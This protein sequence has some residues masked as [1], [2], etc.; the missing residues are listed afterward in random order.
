[1]SIGVAYL[2]SNTAYI[3]VEV[4]QNVRQVLQFREIFHEIA[5]VRHTWHNFVRIVNENVRRVLQFREII[6]EIAA[7]MTSVTILFGVVNWS[8]QAYFYGNEFSVIQMIWW[9]D[10]LDRKG[11][12]WYITVYEVRSRALYAKKSKSWEEVND[13]VMKFKNEK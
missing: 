4:F 11:Y 10:G 6:H 9:K 3:F 12:Y 8:K 5:A 7:V 1:M 13:V 2:V